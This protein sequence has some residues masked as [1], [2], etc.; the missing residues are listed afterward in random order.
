MVP[1]E[2]A[3]NSMDG[4]ENKQIPEQVNQILPLQ[5]LI[6]KQKLSYFGHIM[7]IEGTR[8]ELGKADNDWN[9]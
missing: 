2:D 5:A 8:L 4:Q 9:E 3:T 1:K 7:H 6:S